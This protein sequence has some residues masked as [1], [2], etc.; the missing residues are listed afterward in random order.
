MP[1]S[2]TEYA[3]FTITTFCY[4]VARG[5]A[6]RV[7]ISKLH[8]KRGSELELPT[9]EPDPVYATT[10]KANAAGIARGKA[11]IDARVPGLSGL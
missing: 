2:L 9:P 1:N 6:A 8:V 10:D 7:T 4:T 3:G 5:H 11:A